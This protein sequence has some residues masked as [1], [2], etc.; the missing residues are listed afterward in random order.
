MD[1]EMLSRILAVVSAFGVYLLCARNLIPYLFTASGNPTLLKLSLTSVGFFA[2]L[3]IGFAAL[4]ET[5]GS[6]IASGYAVVLMLAAYTAQACCKSHWQAQEHAQQQQ[7]ET[8]KTL[9][10][11]LR[12]QAHTTP[13][14]TL[15]EACAKAAKTYGLT[16]REE[17]V[18]GLLLEGKRYAEIEQHLCLS[19]STVK[20]HVRN[21]YRKMEVNRRESLF[22]KVDITCSETDNNPL[23]S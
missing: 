1:V 11:T 20:S 6:V 3:V 17:E 4:T 23:S 8:L 5:V 22:Q 21:L 16:R 10:K 18:L 7:I 12:D 15:E 14:L 2:A 13:A 19:H 9:V